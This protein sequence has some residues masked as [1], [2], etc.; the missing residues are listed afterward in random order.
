M[1]NVVVMPKLGLT[2]KKGKIIK[3]FKNEG[4][5]IEAGE[6]LFEVATD[7]L[8]NEVEAKE[9]GIVRKLLADSGDTVPCLEPVAIIGELEEDITEL[10]SGTINNASS[11]SEP[12]QKDKVEIFNKNEAV[13]NKKEKN[14]GRIIA[15]PVAKKLALEKEVDLSYIKGTGPN[16]R[17]TLKDVEKYI[18]NEKCIEGKASPMAV[19]T[20]EKLNVDLTKINMDRRIMKQDVIDFNKDRALEEA[21]N[22]MEQ[23]VSMSQ[24][25]KVIAERMTESWHISPAVTYDMSVD[26]TKLK[27]IKDNLKDV[28]KITYTDLLV[29]IVS[30][31]L[32]EFP[33]LNAS[34]D[35]E[36]MVLRNY[37]N[38]GV[39][40][41]IEN[42]LLVPVVKYAHTKGLRSISE[43]IKELSYKAKTNQLSTDELVGGTF[44]IT[45]LGMFGVESFSPIINQP[46]VAILGV[47]AITEKPI[48]ENG[49]LINKPFIKL[50]LTADHRIADGAVAAQFLYRVKQYI[51]KPD[52]LLL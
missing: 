12:S 42:G 47:N 28:E 52:M 38:M 16:G 43:E 22:P 39:A 14:T 15:S 1:A 44:T 32:L 5:R 19:K 36:E 20:A 33:L 2:M 25:R 45:N 35:G 17:I 34:I 13:E 30:K 49:N 7:K 10:I 6:R 46:E 9:S 50:S 8:T 37:V 41:A 21:I 11:V 51:E 27:E 24:M 18:E 26:V 29:K 48:L 40:V 23:R 3:W 31:V 4:E